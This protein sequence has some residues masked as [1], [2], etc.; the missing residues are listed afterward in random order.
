MKASLVTALGLNAAGSLAAAITI[1]LSLRYGNEYGSQLARI[2]CPLAVYVL[3][4]VIGLVTG[5][6][7]NRRPMLAMLYSL[8]LLLLPMSVLDAYLSQFLVNHAFRIGAT[9]EWAML[10]LLWIPLGCA[11]A[12]IVSVVRWLKYGPRRIVIAW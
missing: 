9:G 7:A 8:L 6:L 2:F 5:I 1:P 12:G 4:L 3:P 10:H 11:G